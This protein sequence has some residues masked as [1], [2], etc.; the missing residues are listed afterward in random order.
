MQVFEQVLA[1]LKHNLASAQAT[2]LFW[3]NVQ[4]YYQYAQRRWVCYLA[5]VE[6]IYVCDGCRMAVLP[7]S[8]EHKS[9]R[10]IGGGP[11]QDTP[12]GKKARVGLDTLGINKTYRHLAQIGAR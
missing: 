7:V 10:N 2:V 9:I 6:K 5:D 11:E 8:K 1:D 12:E 4:S 3:P